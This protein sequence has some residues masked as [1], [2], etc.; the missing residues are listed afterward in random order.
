[1]RD[2]HLLQIVFERPWLITP[3]GHALVARAVE[4]HALRMER[5]PGVDMCGETVPVAQMEIADGQAIIPIKGVIGQGLG[6][7]ERGFG[8]TDINDVRDDFRAAMADESVTDIALWIDSPGGTPSGV[9][10][11]AAEME[12]ARGTKPIVTVCDGDL[13]SA[14]YLLASATEEIIITPTAQAGSIGVYQPFLDRSQAYTAAGLKM[15]VITNGKYKGAGYP[16][17]SLTPDQRAYLLGQVGQLEE[18]FFQAVERNRMASRDSM[19]GQTFIGQ[20]AIDV[21]LA[22]TITNDI[23]QELL[24][25]KG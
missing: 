20:R 17:T 1:M 14:A 6:P 18:M 21:G 22:D 10:E 11:F 7:M 12:D 25:R 16:G 9:F 4:A 3:G 8:A 19:Q 5:A 13:C 2:F 23:R 15:D 24:S